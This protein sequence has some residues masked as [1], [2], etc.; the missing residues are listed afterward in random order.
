VLSELGLGAS[1]IEAAGEI[2]QEQTPAAH[3][4]V[5]FV[6]WRFR[7]SKPRCTAAPRPKITMT[8]GNRLAQLLLRN[9]CCTLPSGVMTWKC[10]RSAI[11]RKADSMRSCIDLLG[12]LE[13]QLG[14]GLTSGTTAYSAP[15]SFPRR[16]LRCPRLAEIDGCCSVEF[17][18]VPPKAV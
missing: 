18:F 1:A 2:P 4:R 14:E 13:T 12:L 7:T 5:W 8:V 6:G 17:R 9:P 16:R 3:L 15:S 10:R 11:R